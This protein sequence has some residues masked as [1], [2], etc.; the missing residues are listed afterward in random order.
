MSI[1]TLRRVAQRK[2]FRLH[3]AGGAFLLIGPKRTVLAVRD[4]SELLA[5]LEMRRAA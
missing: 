3:T 4:R 1:K 5:I 2:G